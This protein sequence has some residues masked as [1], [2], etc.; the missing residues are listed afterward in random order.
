MDVARPVLA[1]LLC[2]L[3]TASST[4]GATPAPSESRPGLDLD[5]ATIPEL[6]HR[7]TDGRLTAVE[8]TTAY[9]RRIDTIDRKV[10]SVLAISPD[11]LAEAAES[12]IRRH[13]GRSL[14]PLDGI[15]VLLKD[16]IDTRALASTAGSRALDTP[17]DHDA[18]LVRRLRGAGA[19]VLGK[20]NLSE[21][22][23]SRSTHATSGWS[24]VDGQTN[25]PY[26]LDRNPCGS[27][28]GSGVA[29][30]ASLAQVAIGTETDGSIVC[31]AGQNGVVGHKPSLGLVSR[32]GVVPVSAEQD[33]A[34]PMARHVVDAAITL[35]VLQGR[36]S[37]DPA[38]ANYPGDQ[39]T[40]YARLLTPGAL[41]GARLGLWRPAG[42][43]TAVDKVMR[44]AV[45]TL[46]AAGATVVEVDLP[47]QDQIGAAESPA[48]LTEFRH[49]LEQYL[50]TRRHAPRTL[51]GLIAFDERDPVELS[52]FGQELFVQAQAAPPTTDPAYQRQRAIATSLAR[53]SIDEVLAAE[54]LDAVVAPTNGPAWKTDYSIGDAFELGSATPAAVAGYP[55]VSVP[56]GFAGPLPLGVSFMAGRW[57]DARV[58]AFA[59]AFEQASNARKAPGYLPTLPR[60]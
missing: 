20:T 12:D 30:A 11:A 23:N 27:S 18:T 55:D 35:S 19:V 60:S 2:V 43:N 56:A 44:S 53:R 52:K 6:Q 33:T 32:A 54:H 9:L 15:P 40:D 26:V 10:N 45:D 46:T 17:P 13:L 47:Y 7:M 49:D 51:A 48:L 3:T 21:W 14:G 36:D 4:S 25:N 8:L 58:L 39:P 38:T 16:N 5:S 31:P 41:R 37:A 24:A 28:S 57:A 22:A 50:A 29:V 34:G 1:A 59:A 42:H